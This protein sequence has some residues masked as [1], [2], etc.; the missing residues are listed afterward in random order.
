MIF[1]QFPHGFLQ[2]DMKMFPHEESRR[3][4]KRVEEAIGELLGLKK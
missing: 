3:A 4:T 2:F 1:D